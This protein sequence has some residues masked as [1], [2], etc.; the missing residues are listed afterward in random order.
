MGNF[1]TFDS[2]IC[3]YLFATNWVKVGEQTINSIDFK[4]DSSILWTTSHWHT[5]LCK[6]KGDLSNIHMSLTISNVSTHNFP[7]L[8]SG[9][10]ARLAYKKVWWGLLQQS[11]FTLIMQREEGFEIN[12]KWIGKN[13]FKCYGLPWIHFRYRYQI[14]RY[15]SPPFPWWIITFWITSLCMTDWL[16]SIHS[17]SL[18]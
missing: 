11:D 10:L 3:I 9:D 1:Q 7:P 17:L 16:A 18:P 14:F 13:K 12:L 2:N 5:L 6:V 8:W 4:L 15:H